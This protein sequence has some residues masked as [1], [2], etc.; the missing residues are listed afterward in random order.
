MNLQF[1]FHKRVDNGL[2]EN[3][4]HSIMEK[5]SQKNSLFYDKKS[6]HVCVQAD[7]K[8]LEEFSDT[9]SK[10]LPV[11]LFYEFIDAKVVEEFPDDKEPPKCELCLPF[12]AISLDEFLDKNS[13]NFHNV[14]LKPHV[15]KELFVSKDTAFDK[16]TIEKICDILQSGASIDA[17]TSEGIKSLKIVNEDSIEAK[18]FYIMPTDSSLIDRMCIASKDEIQA[19]LSFEKPM[20]NLKQ[21]LV[22][23]SKNLLSSAWIDMRLAD[24]LFL[25]ALTSEL[26]KRGVEFLI[27]QEKKDENI[28]TCNQNESIKPLKVNV[29]E[30][31][32][33]LP[34]ENH[35]Y[36]NQ[37]QFPNFKE[38][39]HERFSTL[40][41]EYNLF[42]QKSICFFL[43]K[44]YDDSIMF[45]SEKTGL[46]ELFEI[47]IPKDMSEV[48]AMIQSSESGEKLLANYNEQY[49]E[50]LKKDIEFKNMP[51]NFH[52]LLGIV[53]SVLGFGDD[54]QSGAAALLEN[55]KNCERLKGVRI[56]VLLDEKTHPKKL[57]VAKFIQSGLS[58]KLAGVEDEVLSF[59]YLESIAYMLSSMSDKLGEEFGSRYVTMAGELFSFKRFLEVSVRNIQPNHKVC[60]NRTFA[61]E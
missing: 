3:I 34:L 29:L 10:Y 58:F 39:S 1:N 17:N 46:V 33:I 28:F 50:L 20:L 35:P 60:I 22:Y 49:P 2:L 11:S 31:G 12:D 53:G 41:Y 36:L 24:T 59:G 45:Y 44:K 48:I 8:G 13:K 38:K 21:N 57:N 47:E 14:F 18:D 56:D 30:N 25:Y 55:A 37:H 19:L 26:F 40:L 6:V 4:L 15:G 42:E 32:F 23:K 5:S 27:V 61:L 52:T 54:V 9:L 7:E 51:K 16:K 43:S